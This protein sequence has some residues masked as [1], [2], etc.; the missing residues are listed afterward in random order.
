MISKRP[1]ILIAE[2]DE[3]FATQLLEI[4][5]GEGYNT[6]RAHDGSEAL[7]VLKDRVV[8]VGFIDLYMPGVDGMQVIEQAAKIAPDTPLV[9][10]T[11]IPSLEKAV[12]AT[13]LGAYNFIEK[14][15]D[16]NRLLLTVENALE[17]RALVLKNKWMADEI[18]TRY[19]MIG[20]SESMR[21]VYDV[22]DKIAETDS[23]VLITGESGTGKELAARAI[24][25]QSGRANGPFIKVN[26]AAIPETLIESEL[27]GHKKYSFTNAMQDR[28]GKFVQADGGTIFLDE[29]GDMSK[30]AQAKILRVLQEKEV[31]RIGDSAP[32]KVD[33]R[34]IAA[35]N[36]Q[37]KER[38]KAN[39]FRE[40]LFYRL[41]TIEI[42]LPP[43]SER[44]DDIPKLIDHFLEKSCEKNN[45]YV[46]GF[47]PQAFQILVDYNWPG[48]VR[49]LENMIDR[50]IILA[51]DKVLTAQEVSAQL[52]GNAQTGSI[53]TDYRTA[54]QSYEKKYITQTLLAQKWNIGI[55]AKVMGIDRTNL[56]KK[57]KKMGIKNEKRST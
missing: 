37:L 48:N 36:K 35:T 42:N 17:K 51:D 24:H 4:F 21:L 5:S 53:A 57:M 54:M 12:K 27:F 15:A 43:L 29:I 41:S 56:F 52:L 2:D 22:I 31:E 49:E 14:P 40:D 3:S 8:D 38:I 47:E 26:C 39:F 1:T 33:V 34:V 16:L 11:G 9:M 45:R 6:V 55:A 46:R 19:K 18:Q 32:I 28:D 13:Q 44:K 10:I 20:S 25:Q 30:S 23:T 50:L 7:A